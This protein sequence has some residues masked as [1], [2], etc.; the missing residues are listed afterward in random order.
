MALRSALALAAVAACCACRVSRRPRRLGDAGGVDGGGG[1]CP[2]GAANRAHRQQEW[3]RRPRRGRHRHGSGVRPPIRIRPL[4][5]RSGGTSSPTMARRSCRSAATSNRSLRK[6]SRASGAALPSA[7]R[8]CT[9]TGSTWRFSP[10]VRGS[11]AQPC[12]GWR[13]STIPDR[14]SGTGRCPSCRGGPPVLT[15]PRPAGQAGTPRRGSRRAVLGRL[16]LPRLWVSGGP[17]GRVRPV[18]LSLGPNG[19]GGL[20]AVLVYWTGSSNPRC[21]RGWM[22]Q[23]SWRW[24]RSPH[25]PAVAAAA[26]VG[27][28][29]PA[30][31][32]RHVPRPAATRIRGA[33]AGAMG[34]RST[35]SG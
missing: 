23:R 18:G 4:W 19:H 14:S 30:G 21:G 27:L 22:R 26:G 32:G 20:A 15:R 17:G 6:R 11:D 9:A 34:I 29:R 12:M 1:R 10:P 28:F 24:R 5:T 8:A 25:V 3:R 7:A 33:P 35:P 31:G 16:R 13:S 2:P